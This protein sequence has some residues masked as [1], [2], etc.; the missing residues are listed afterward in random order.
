MFAL[1]WIGQDKEQAEEESEEFSLDC[2]GTVDCGHCVGVQRAVVWNRVYLSPLG[3]AGFHTCA[4][5]G[6]TLRIDS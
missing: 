4:I 1:E 2:E 5:E 6:N 3:E